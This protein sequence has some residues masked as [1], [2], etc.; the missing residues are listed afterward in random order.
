MQLCHH[1]SAKDALQN[2]DELHETIQV[3]SPLAESDLKPNENN[4]KSLA[5]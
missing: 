1:Q 3:F 5:P 4:N 2:W